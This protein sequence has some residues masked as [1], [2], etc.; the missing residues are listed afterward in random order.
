MCVAA[1]FNIVLEDVLEDIEY[2][3]C[4]KEENEIIEGENKQGKFSK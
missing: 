3:V 4:E 2:D 1:T